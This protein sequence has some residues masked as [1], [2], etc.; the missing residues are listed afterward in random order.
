MT[1]RVGDGPKVEYE[2][3]VSIRYSV[4]A[5]NGVTIYKD[6]EET[7]VSGQLQPNRGLDAAL[8]NLSEGSQAK[9]ILPSEQAFGVA[10]DGNRVK[11]C[12][13]LIYDVEVLKVKKMK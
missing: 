13:V 10:G 3:T 9:V 7:V 4:E 5:I 1:T 11:S 8:R 2:D 6:Q 12:M